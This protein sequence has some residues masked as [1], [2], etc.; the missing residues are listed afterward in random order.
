MRAF[1]DKVDLFG[2]FTIGYESLS[3]KKK[4]PFFVQVSAKKGLNFS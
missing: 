1:I 2:V 4:T 3:R